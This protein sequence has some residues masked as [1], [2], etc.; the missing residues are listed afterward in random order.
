MALQTATTR[1]RDRAKNRSRK[2]PRKS[3]CFLPG[4]FLGGTGPLRGTSLS[5]RV[6]AGVSGLVGGAISTA[7]I[8]AA[9]GAA[10]VVRATDIAVRTTRV[11]VPAGV[12]VAVPVA[13]VVVLVVGATAVAV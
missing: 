5:I 7:S 9:V 1:Y 3:C 10:G 4:R 8:A 2:S 13:T 12:V 11:V 6:S